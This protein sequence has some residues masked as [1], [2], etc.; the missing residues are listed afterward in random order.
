MEP[1][2][3][4]P[5]WA[6]DMAAN[7]SGWDYWVAVTVRHEFVLDAIIA[8]ARTIAKYETPPV[9]H[10]ELKRWQDAREAVAIYWEGWNDKHFAR[11]ARAGKD[12]KSRE[13]RSAYIA[14]CHRDGVK[15]QDKA[16]GA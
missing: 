11:Q 3:L 9:D 4:P 13:V 12:D 2:E 14:L 8:H 10:A 1:T 6:L 15:P 16:P 5:L 7:L